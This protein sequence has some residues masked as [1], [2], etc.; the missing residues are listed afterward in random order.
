MTRG[1]T[2]VL[3]TCPKDPE[4]NSVSGISNCGWLNRLKKSARNSKLVDSASFRN[5]NVLSTERSVLTCPG[6]WMMPTGLLPKPVPSPT[7]GELVKQFVSKYLLSRVVRSLERFALQP[8]TYW[9]KS[10]KV[11]NTLVGLKSVTVMRC[12]DWM[13]PTPLKRHPPS[14][15]PIH[16]VRSCGLGKS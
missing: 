12:P 5:G 1:F 7:V 9:A 2:T 13:V 15:C 11:P 4:V 16:E 6:P 8:G 14:N 10:L 3:V